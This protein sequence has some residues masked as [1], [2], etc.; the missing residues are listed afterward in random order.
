MK[1]I[2]KE[3]GHRGY[4]Y[5][6]SDALTIMICGMLYNLQTISDIHEWSKSESIRELL[7]KEFGIYKYPSRAQFYNLI[8]CINPQKFIYSLIIKTQL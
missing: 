5:K 7:L 2:E 4:Y 1:E 8:G 3:S 6:V